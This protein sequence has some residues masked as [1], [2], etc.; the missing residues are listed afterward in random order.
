MN[1]ARDRSTFDERL[2]AWRPVAKDTQVV[3][4]VKVDNNVQLS[5]EQLEAS[6]RGFRGYAI[7]AYSSLFDSPNT[8][9]D[10]QTDSAREQRQT[11]R[12]AIM[13][14]LQE[15]SRSGAAAGRD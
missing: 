7:F 15:L 13:P 11:R 12:K 5:A 2:A 1:Y 14:H 8:T 10:E 6:L 4:G 9:L 3:M